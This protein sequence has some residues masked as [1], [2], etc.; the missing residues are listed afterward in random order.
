M[1]MDESIHPPCCLLNC[2]S[3]EVFAGDLQRRMVFEFP[4]PLTERSPSKIAAQIH[5]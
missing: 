1:T 2:C 3:V 4:S 5:A